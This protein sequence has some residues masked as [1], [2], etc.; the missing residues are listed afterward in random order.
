MESLHVSS[1]SFLFFFNT[2]G[3][4]SDVLLRP[5]TRSSSSSGAQGTLD[6]ALS[7][8]RDGTPTASLVQIIIN[9]VPT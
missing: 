2:K 4:F 1:F 3:T 7:T 8:F 5:T 6:L 9:V